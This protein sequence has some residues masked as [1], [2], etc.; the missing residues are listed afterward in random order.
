LGSISPEQGVFLKNIGIAGSAEELAASAWGLVYRV[1]VD[2]GPRWEEQKKNK[3]T[4]A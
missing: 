4:T 3:G 1:V 2:T